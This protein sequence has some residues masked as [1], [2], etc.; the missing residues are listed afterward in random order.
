MIGTAWV[1]EANVSGSLSSGGS[2]LS[3]RD[4]VDELFL[5][6]DLVDFKVG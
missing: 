3:A 6:G 5:A 2:G 4:D 1:V